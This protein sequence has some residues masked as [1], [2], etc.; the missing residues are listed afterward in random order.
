[1]SNTSK[2]KFLKSN[3]NNVKDLNCYLDRLVGEKVAV[4]CGD[5]SGG[6]SQ[7]YAQAG[8]IYTDVTGNG[9]QAT[10]LTITA[11]NL[12]TVDGT[13]ISNRVVTQNGF[14]TNF[15]GGAFYLSGTVGTTPVSGA[16]PRVMWVPA[17]Q[18]FRAGNPFSSLWDDANI[19]PGSIAL[20]RGN[21]AL[22]DDSVALGLGSVA[23]GVNSFAVSG[24]IAN[25][26]GSFAVGPT[27][28][29]DGLY[30]VAMGNASNATGDY[31]IAMGQEAIASGEFSVVISPRYGMAQAQYSTAIG[32]NAIVSVSG[33]Y[34]TAIGYQNRVFSTESMAAGANSRT[35][36]RS[37]FTFGRDVE[38]YHY[39]ETV[40][41]MSNYTN[42]VVIDSRTD[43]NARMFVVGNGTGEISDPVNRSN[44]IIV[45]RGGI[46]AA[47]IAINPGQIL[48]PPTNTMQIYGDLR[49]DNVTAVPT[50]LMGATANNVLGALTLGAGI[51]ITG[52][53]LN[54]TSG[55]GINIYT[56]DGTLGASR[57]VNMAGFPLQFTNAGLFRIEDTNGVGNDGIYDFNQGIDFLTYNANFSSNI[58]SNVLNGTVIS[59]NDLVTPAN[60]VSVNV[61]S[62]LIRLTNPISTGTQ[63]RIANFGAAANGSVLSLADNTTGRV[64]WT[65][66]PAAIT[67]INSATNITQLLTVGTAGTDF[68]IDSVGTP[69]THIF[70]IP[71]ASA[72][73]RGLVTTGT[74]T[75]AGNKTFSGN[76]QANGVQTNTSSSNSPFIAIGSGVISSATADISLEGAATGHYR[77]ISNGLGA[78]LGVN[79][80]YATMYIRGTGPTEAASGTHPLIANVAIKSLTLVNG[81]ASTTNTASLYIEGAMTGV[82]PTGAAYAIWSKAGLNRFGGAVGIGIAS[83]NDVSSALQIDST[84]Q[85]VLIPRMTMTQRDAI[86]TPATGLLIFQTDNTP[87]FYWY[88]GAAWTAI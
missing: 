61:N 39:G 82:T 42:G 84:T 14:Y 47:K 15:T 23:I 59:Y 37:S 48:T 52:G 25:G 3:F 18:A 44:A 22:G 69:G 12:Y 20:G 55:A 4:I 7:I 72:T 5:C 67:S 26:E 58:A 53:Q 76:V 36:T 43:V 13:L 66:I 24:A 75:I 45:Y 70:N 9:L 16:G 87:G 21:M 85:G 73:A 50:K 79:T 19:G 83:V 71:S 77:I 65:T 40:V 17:K 41:G 86:A 38:T 78:T 32:Y 68:N 74:Q 54:F 11:N 33:Q 63:F 62:Q 80:S 8:N 64:A 29:A 28:G 1:M 49:V 88:N 57:T 34:S 10:P 27:Y 56:T 6:I 30:S 51:S 81:T 60:N 2:N 46:G 35:H 31:S